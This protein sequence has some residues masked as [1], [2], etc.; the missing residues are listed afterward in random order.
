M[1]TCKVLQSIG[2]WAT[3]T[4]KEKSREKNKKRDAQRCRASS[5]RRRVRC[6][7]RL[8]T[9][10][11]FRVE[12]R[13]S[14]RGDVARFPFVHRRHLVSTR[15]AS[16]WVARFAALPEEDRNKVLAAIEDASNDGLNRFEDFN[17]YTREIFEGV[18]AQGIPAM[19]GHDELS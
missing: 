8:A 13:R 12:D 14:R 6:L 7:H 15:N 9:I 10:A 16:R 2:E 17:D 3:T 19:Q 5:R 11:R 4:R 18:P 1:A